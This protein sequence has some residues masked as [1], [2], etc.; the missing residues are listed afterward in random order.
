MFYIK[1]FPHCMC[2][3]SSC[4]CVIS[5]VAVIRKIKCNKFCIF[6]N[7]NTD[8][9]IPRLEN[10]ATGTATNEY[11]AVPITDITGLC[12]CIDIG[13]KKAAVMQRP[14]TLESD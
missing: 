2:T 9:I 14:N 6:L 10:I 5:F 8:K 3:G 7:G 13:D 11:A 1:C 12:V 4:K